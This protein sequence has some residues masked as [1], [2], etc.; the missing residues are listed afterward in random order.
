VSRM[1][2]ALLPSARPAAVPPPPGKS[3][4]APCLVGRGSHQVIADCQQPDIQASRQPDG[5]S[6]EGASPRHQTEP[7]LALAGDQGVVKVANEDV[8]GRPASAAL[9]VPAFLS[10]FFIIESFGPFLMGFWLVS[11]QHAQALL[12]LPTNAG[13]QTLML[14]QLVVG[15]NVVLFASGSGASFPWPSRPPAALFSLLLLAQVATTLICA[16][17]VLVEP[18]SWQVIGWVWAYN[19]MWLAILRGIWLTVGCLAPCC[20]AP[21]FEQGGE[22]PLIVAATAAG[23]RGDRLRPYLVSSERAAA[24]RLP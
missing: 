18:I 5:E 13:L 10:V 20:A 16:T 8:G 21:E 14:L 11:S 15:G 3:V 2:P 17:G 23:D 19:L 6:V 4:S 9:A 7:R 22:G 24:D 1:T 12:D